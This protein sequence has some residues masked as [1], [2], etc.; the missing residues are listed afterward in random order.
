MFHG[1]GAMTGEDL[2]FLVVDADEESNDL[3]RRTLEGE[4]HEVDIAA[5]PQTCRRYL[6]STTYQAVFLDLYSFGLNALKVLDE[7]KFRLQYAEIIIL[8]DADEDTAL[9]VIRAHH[10]SAYMVK[11][12]TFTSIRE[13]LRHLQSRRFVGLSAS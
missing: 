2:R 5:D 9:D 6:S 11:P 13:T 4:G 7:F 3:F 1:E 10:A 8:C 12:V